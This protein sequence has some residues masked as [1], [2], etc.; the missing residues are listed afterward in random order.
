MRHAKTHLHHP[1]CSTIYLADVQPAVPRRIEG[2]RHIV[3]IC[4]GSLGWMSRTRWRL[5]ES[6]ALDVDVFGHHR[7]GMYRAVSRAGYLR[8]LPKLRARLDARPQCLHRCP[9]RTAAL[10]AQHSDSV[11]VRG[12]SGYASACSCMIQC[13]T[14]VLDCA[15]RPPGTLEKLRTTIDLSACA[16]ARGAARG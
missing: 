7:P 5:S 10:A 13:L 14:T 9:S 12:G 3:A 15:C 8:S 6:L 11:L 2:F 1:V 16:S 4:D